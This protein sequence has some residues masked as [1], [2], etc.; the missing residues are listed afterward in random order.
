[1]TYRPQLS[2]ASRDFLPFDQ[3]VFG[4][5]NGVR[6]VEVLAEHAVAYRIAQRVTGLKTEQPLY[7][8]LGTCPS[9][10][11]FPK[12]PRTSQPVHCLSIWG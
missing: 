12:T 5:L 8:T 2:D 10:S 9:Q 11:F 3:F 4:E 7:E 6:P 1:M